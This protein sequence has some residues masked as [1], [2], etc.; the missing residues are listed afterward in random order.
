MPQ[1]ESE[2][3]RGRD[4]GER[5]G[6]SLPVAPARRRVSGEKRFSM[7]LS[8]VVPVYN[9]A[10]VLPAL[11]QSLRAVLG[12]MDCEYELIFINDGSR[13]DSLR[14]L[15]QEA[16]ADPRIKVLGFSRNFGHQT[17]ITAGLDFAAGDAVVI[18]D[19]DL[20]DPP[21]VLPKMVELFR[22]GYDVVSAQRQARDGDGV[23]KRATASLFY[24]FMRRAVDRRLVPEVGDFR[25]F[26]RAAIVV[27]RSF[28]E[29]HRFMSGAS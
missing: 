16:W 8:V 19:A 28:R 3:E 17:A 24:W 20:Q 22:R 27:L 7:L 9:E 29:Q 14:I 12:R 18:M 21:E 13:D 10:A 5:S 15:S 25:L 26:S 4:T 11:L 1:R 6:L 2:L 23:F